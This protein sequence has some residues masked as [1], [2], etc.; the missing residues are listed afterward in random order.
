MDEYR[1]DDAYEK[2]YEYD[3]KARA[4]LFIGTYLAYGINAPMS[5]DVK[6]AAIDRD[7][8]RSV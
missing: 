4:Y 7:K 6:V 5:D 8:M 2:I 3:N 1:F